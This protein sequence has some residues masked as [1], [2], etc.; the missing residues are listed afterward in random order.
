MASLLALAPHNRTS[1]RIYMKLQ[2][3]NL[4]LTTTLHLDSDVHSPFFTQSAGI[5]K[6]YDLDDESDDDDLT[7]GSISLATIDIGVARTLGLSTQ[8]L[9]WAVEG[10]SSDYGDFADDF[11]NDDAL[12]LLEY[13]YPAIY[14]GKILVLDN[15]TIDPKF[16]NMGVGASVVKA[17]QQ[18]FNYCGLFALKP[19]AIEAPRLDP[20]DT[21]QE[22]R[23]KSK[24]LDAGAKRLTTFYN[25]LGFRLTTMKYMTYSPDLG[26]QPTLAQAEKM[27]VQIIKEC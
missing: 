2:L 26:V 16:R 20:D 19:F 18:H 23:K 1:K 14:S 10:E 7:A 5:V 13:S 9:F 27:R 3:S 11:L 25:G 17:I 12:S 4:E 6:A 22:H 15:L 24:V 8:D 21:L